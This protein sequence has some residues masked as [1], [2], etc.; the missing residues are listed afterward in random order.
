MPRGND[1]EVIDA[2][3]AETLIEDNRANWPQELRSASL[4]PV[5]E[6][7][8]AELDLESLSKQFKGGEVVSAAV[9]GGVT[10][11][12]VDYDG[13]VRKFALDSSD[14]PIT[15]APRDG[16]GPA[17]DEDEG[18]PKPKAKAKAKS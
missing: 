7:A 17:D 11:V 16:E 2:A 5:D 1:P 3:S 10:I 12:A 18:K 14:E 13:I 8:T 9:R 15:A 4:R 6:Q